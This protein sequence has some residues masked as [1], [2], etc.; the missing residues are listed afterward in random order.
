MFKTLLSLLLVLV[1]LY[2]ALSAWVFFRQRDFIYFP[3]FTHADLPPTNL[4]LPVEDVVLRGWVVNP[5]KR[6]AVI[7]FG[8]NAEPVQAMR[9]ELAQWLPGH[10]SYLA[11]YRGYGASDG[12]P[13]ERA[14]TADALALYD[15]V[16]SRHPDGSITV[17][18]RSLG[19]GVASHLAAR[20]PVARL[21][22]I[23]PFD[24]MARLA[25][26]HYSFLPVRWLLRDRYE[27]ARHLKHYR[28]PVLIVRASNDRIVPA[29]RTMQL[30]ESL[31][32]RPQVVA[33]PGTDHNTLS[34][35][36]GYRQ[37][38]VDFVNRQDPPE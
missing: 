30:A 23:T 22:L 15:L 6:D 34:Y 3:Q 36:P 18:G 10:S 16:R 8:G 24:S 33:L 31:P 20:R 1:L 4:E 21:V 38:I 32:V 11:A 14:L 28:G 35:G 19:S 17:I 29:E 2:A 26:T 12:V 7:Y 25:Q 5:G 9:A 13:G 37:A 27:S